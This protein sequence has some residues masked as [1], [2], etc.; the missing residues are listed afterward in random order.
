MSF[1]E[2]ETASEYTVDEPVTPYAGRGGFNIPTEEAE[3][4]PLTKDEALL[5]L[6]ESWTGQ[7]SL[8][9]A[10]SFTK[11]R[12]DDKIASFLER[13]EGDLS[14]GVEEKLRLYLRTLESYAV[15]AYDEG[16]TGVSA[17][18]MKQLISVKVMPV[19]K[20]VLRASI[21]R[22]SARGGRDFIPGRATERRNT[23][24]ISNRQR[25]SQEVEQ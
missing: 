7:S 23:R 11:D 8:Y 9:V 21:R 12:A 19:I 3:G 20:Q 15:R 4:P 6:L 17:R 25:V 10:N 13:H 22:R 18:N 2:V 14:D 1:E 5:G 16:N 24:E